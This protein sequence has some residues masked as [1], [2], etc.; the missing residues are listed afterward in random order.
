M[1]DL[2]IGFL[3]IIAKNISSNAIVKLIQLKIFIK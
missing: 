1:V 2:L 3:Y